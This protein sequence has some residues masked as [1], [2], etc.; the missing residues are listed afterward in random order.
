MDP[1]TL[2]HAFTQAVEAEDGARLAA[3][4]TP[5]GVYHDVFYGSFAGRERIAAMITDR[6]ARDATEFRWDMHDPVC[7][8]RTLYARYVFSYRSKLPESEGRRALFEGVAIMTLRDGLIAAYREVANPG[9]GLVTMGFAPERVA[10]I[11]Q[12]VAEALQ[13][14]REAARHRTG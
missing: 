2:L 4:F 11:L 5:D 1:D 10:K 6:F 3:L 12:R 8:G 13:A 7:D 14:R 9:P